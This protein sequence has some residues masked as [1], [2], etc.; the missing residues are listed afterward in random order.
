M[1]NLWFVRMNDDEQ[2][3]NHEYRYS[4]EGGD[5]WVNDDITNPVTFVAEGD[6]AFIKRVPNRD[7]NEQR[8]PRGEENIKRLWEVTN[9]DFS[10]GVISFRPIEIEFEIVFEKFTSLDLFKLN[11]NTMN[12]IQ[13]NDRGRSF[14]LLDFATQ[15]KEQLIFNNYKEPEF[16]KNYFNAEEHY[17]KIVRR[18]NLTDFIEDSID[19][20]YCISDNSIEYY[21][22]DFIDGLTLQENIVEGISQAQRLYPV[23][24]NRVQAIN[25]FKRLQ[26]A[27]GE[28]QVNIRTLYNLI[29]AHQDFVAKAREKEEQNDSAKL[30][31]E[32]EKFSSSSEV[33]EKLGLLEHAKNI[34]LHGA[35]G[36]GKTYLANQIAKEL[37]A[38]KKENIGFVQF[39]PSYDYTD[40]VEGLRPVKNKD[41]IGFDRKDGLFK[42]FCEKAIENPKD[43]F[44][45]IID[46]I[47][48]GE[49][50][51]I[52][53][54]L[55][56]SID[57]GYR[58]KLEDKKVSQETKTKM[59]FVK[60]QYANMCTKANQFDKAIGVKDKD[61]GHFF[62]PDNV[63]IIGTMNDI[64]RSVDSMDF[65][66]RRRFTFEE[67][68]AE[69]SS[70]RML[71]DPEFEKAKN[72]M[73]ALNDEI[74]NTEGLS[75]SYQVGAAYF[76]KLKKLN[77]NFEK[78]WDYH[79][80]GLLREYLRGFDDVQNK[81]DELKKAY[82]SNPEAKK[83][84]DKQDES[85]Q[86]SVSENRS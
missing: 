38:G 74:A 29:F 54:E 16:L 58:V 43:K 40:F 22:A 2:I 78:L 82:N 50:S 79:L 25:T 81:L 52:F 11:I 19:F 20:Q 32:V 65:A 86:E 56:Y 10:N 4:V 36:T 72:R 27:R 34:I 66:F 76:L 33:V 14:F 69:E 83:Q 60:T 85:N 5:S 39:H 73:K 35:P 26:Q 48:R 7:N 24:A 6:L 8:V 71:T 68:T 3:R 9:C 1:A 67:I 12:K 75:S 31:N 45:F 37:V 59:Q 15:E 51:K 64:D 21:R 77:F 61:Y 44:V 18:M 84:D 63:Y 30:S 49:M 55:F 53:G 23:G 42:T 57:P 46:E 47:N 80:E 28:V 62:V 13:N 17:R 41:Q 70:E